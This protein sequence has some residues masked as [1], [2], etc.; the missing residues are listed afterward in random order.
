MISV[1]RPFQA[2][3]IVTF[4]KVRRESNFTQVGI[5]YTYGLLHVPKEGSPAEIQTPTH[6]KLIG[7]SMTAPPPVL[8]PS[9]TLPPPSCHCAFTPAKNNSAHL[10]K[11]I[12]LFLLSLKLRKSE[13]A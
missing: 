8:S 1:Y 13:I 7:H 2:Y 11:V 3:A 4:R 6:W 5:E 10:K 9:I 12:V